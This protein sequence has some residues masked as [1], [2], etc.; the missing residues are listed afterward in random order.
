MKQTKFFERSAKDM[1]IAIAPSLL[2]LVLALFFVKKFINPAPPN[3]IVI[4]TSDSEGDYQFYAKQYQEIM[5]D[6][7][8][9]LEI[10]P[11]TGAIENLRRLQDEKSDVDVGFV[12]DGLGSTEEETDLVSLGSL[13]YEPIW[14]FYRGNKKLDRIVQLTGKRIAV[15]QEGG[16]TKILALKL[17]K[18]A[19]IDEKTAHLES[20]GW[21]KA[22]AALRVNQIDAAIFLATPRDA[23]IIDLMHDKTIHLMSMDQAEAITRQ[24]PYLHHLVLPHGALDLKAGIPEQDVD[25]V[26]PT[27][28]LLVKDTVHS[29]LVYLL[30]KAASQVH[31]DPGIFE[32]KNEFPMDKD[33]QFPLSEE[34]KSF[35]KSGTP[36]WQRFLPFWLAALVERF[37]F[38]IIPILAVVLPMIKMIPRFYQWRIHNRIFQRYGELKFIE[39]QVRTESSKDKLDEYVKKLDDIEDRVN[40]M[41][42][43]LDFSS[44]IY[45]LRGHIHFV[46]ERLQE[47]AAKA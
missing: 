29:A 43:P 8:V 5:K 4:S 17:L 15:G 32:K 30:L 39:T 21:D 38:L 42:V 28:T 2:L 24:I 14:I 26:S 6:D 33:F 11:S 40:H 36:F 10:R 46:R 23:Q 27:A 19:G 3:H 37:I 47:T 22:S 16:G 9:T 25:L 1:L 34:A 7:G 20:L 18:E 45:E 44:H 12:Q 35:Y 13:Y 31:D 41:K